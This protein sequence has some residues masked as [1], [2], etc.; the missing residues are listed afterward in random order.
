MTIRELQAALL[1]R[2]Y[3]PG[4]VDGMMGP[5][6]RK[7]ILAFQR[8]NGLDVD[9]IVGPKT[10]AKLFGAAAEKPKADKSVP[11]DLPWLA[12]AQRLRGL[13]EVEGAGDNP[14]IMGWARDLDAPYSSDE[15][16]WCGLFVTHCIRSALPDA[17]VP[18][19]FLGA[20]QWVKFGKTVNPQFGSVLV[21]WRG[22]R[23]GWK[24]HVGFYWAEDETHF[25]VLG[26]NQ[27][28][29]VCVSRLPKSRLLEAR[30]PADLN[31]LGITRVA[32]A[33]GALVSVSEA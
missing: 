18:A 1:A 21:F 22:E 10:R 2:N 33:D 16:A 19:N 25:H 11:L 32:S 14:V 7:A 12:E 17:P 20:R 26:G 4:P 24:G 27:S 29:S 31:A 3:N 6:T 5:L 8:D 9:G 30:W 13:K 23:N 28:N 15:V